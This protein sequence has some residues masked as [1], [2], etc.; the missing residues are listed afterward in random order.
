MKE[1]GCD[2]DELAAAT[3]TVCAPMDPVDVARAKA[4]SFA[5][6]DDRTGALDSLGGWYTCSGGALT[7]S[8]SL[9]TVISSTDFIAS[10]SLW[11]KIALSFELGDMSP[12]EEKSPPAASLRL[13]LHGG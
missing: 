10:A 11:S 6:A 2:R 12:P 1:F 13:L 9:K 4:F 7:L 3:E 8:V 5:P